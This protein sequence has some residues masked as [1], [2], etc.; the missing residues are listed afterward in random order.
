M[1]ETP[2]RTSIDT[3][4]PRESAQLLSFSCMGRV[5]YFSSMLRP[6]YSLAT[7]SPSKYWEITLVVVLESILIPVKLKKKLSVS[8]KF[9]G[10]EIKFISE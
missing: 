10:R 6:I 3:F 9:R 4:G 7:C 1:K 2:S 8:Y 5:P